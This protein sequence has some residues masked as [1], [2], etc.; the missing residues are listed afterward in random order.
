MAMRFLVKA[1]L[2]SALV[3]AV[4]WLVISYGVT[5]AVERV[6]KR[7]S[8]DKAEHWGT[9]MVD[10]IPDLPE[11]IATGRPTQEQQKVIRE[12]REVGNIFKFKLFNGDGQLVF[13]SDAQNTGFLTVLAD[14]V[15]SE[16]RS[17]ATT[18]KPIVGVFD[19]TKKPDRPDL[20][21][22][23]YVPLFSESGTLVGVAEVYVDQADTSAY[24]AESF[25]DFGLWLMVLC[26]SIFAVPG[27]AFWLQRI[28]AQRSQK[29]AEFLARFDALTGVLNRREFVAQADEM[30]NRSELSVLCFLDLDR[31]KSINDTY[32]HGAGDEFLAHVSAVLR[33]NCRSED[34]LA[35]FGGDEFVIAFKNMEF[36]DAIQRVRT[37]L[38]E[39]AREV[40]VQDITLVGSV[41][42]GLA[43]VKP[44]ENL[45]QALGNADTALYHVKAAGRN[46][47]AVYG[48]EMGEE[49][50][51]RRA[52]E[53]RL[54]EALRNQ[55]FQVH[56]QP[57]VDGT[58][59]TVVGHEAL[60]RLYDHDGND[61]PPTEFIPLA[62]E[63]GLIQDIGKWVLTTAT[64]EMAL[65]GGDK[66]LA[67]NMS[68][69]QFAGEKLIGMVKEALE[70]S[71]FPPHRLELEITE[72]LLLND[73][74]EIALQIDTLKE[75]GVGITMDDFGTGFSSLSY[76]WKYGFDRLKIDR[77]FVAALSENPERSRDIIE[78]IVLL[79]GRLDMKITAE[80]VET[81]DQSALLSSLGCDVLQGFLFGKAMPFTE[82]PNDA[83]QSTAHPQQINSTG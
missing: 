21:A 17:V 41:S 48:H 38:K 57:L 23:A 72:S 7:E 49:L 50:R 82:L 29:Q 13:V 14:T 19:G 69:M 9:Y 26:A 25:R 78:T 56:Y 8:I 44:G 28:F 12:V 65:L 3:V 61:I 59:G 46:D 60:L 11:L 54:R 83:E 16:P 62:E 79:G 10:R 18:G 55:D 22:E 75:M 70:A 67:V 34:L 68:A 73:S 36:E 63:L 64:R 40:E 45:E 53:A 76:L 15:D 30:V 51:R 66:M 2:L 31:F 4:I 74:P 42:V 1:G 32:G 81:D 58:D 43:A 20:Y 27:S 71:G 47:F 6:I 77:S 80:G 39:C 5:S 35:R 37:I 52:L 24:F 33:K